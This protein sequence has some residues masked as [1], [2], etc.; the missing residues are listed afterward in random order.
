MQFTS[1]L[2]RERKYLLNEG[3]H[4]LSERACQKN[5]WLQ[6]YGAVLCLAIVSWLAS[7]S[8][9]ILNQSALPPYVQELGLTTH[10]GVIFASFLVAETLF[11]SPMGSLGDKVGRRPIIAIGAFISGLAAVGMS[12]ANSLWTLIVLEALGGIG[13]AA[14]W[15]TITAAMGGAAPPKRRTTAMSVMMVTYMTGL[16]LGPLVGGFANDCTNSRRTSFY[17]VGVLFLITAVI[18]WLLT[19]HRTKE[20]VEAGLGE[21]EVALKPSDLL[22]GLKSVPD[23]MLIAFVAFFAIGLL[24]PVVKLF[25]MNELG[26]SETS[27]GLLL[28]PLAS[29]VAG[30]SLISG[31][32]GDHWGKAQSVHVGLLICSVAMWT[33]TVA[34]ETWQFAIAGT[35]LGVGFV[36]AMPAWLAFISEISAPLVRGAVIGALA[37][38]QGIGAVAGA[39]A[40]SYLY[41]LVRINIWGKE[42][43]LSSHYSPFVV[44]AM[45]LT[46]CFILTL[47]FVRDGDKRRIG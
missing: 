8:Y 26:L 6:T 24:I 37:T 38:A 39:S 30:V 3:K 22:V 10:V 20:E 13:C 5:S 42:L 18:S 9:S 47:Y 46:L 41:K 40:G 14:V 1:L 44:S 15:P 21:K 36:I 27:Y 16:A 31:R 25:A 29:V 11:K 4:P 45:A 2:R 35:F 33:I 43:P 19:P 7:L 34:K 28:L 17:I 23:M 12:V 32:L